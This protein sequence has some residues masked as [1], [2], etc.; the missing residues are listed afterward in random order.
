MHTLALF[1]Q[2]HMDIVF[3]IYG[4]AFFSLGLVIL[5]QP[6]EE[7]KYGL[8]SIFWLLAVFGLVHG[9]LEW[10]DLWGIVRGKTAALDTVKIPFLVV[11]YLFL[12]EFGR[13]LLLVSGK[14][15]PAPL[16]WL[17]QK[18]VYAWVAASFMVTFFMIPDRILATQISARYFLGLTGACYTG[19]GFFLY[20][21]W[22]CPQR[23]NAPSLLWIRKYFMLSA[24]AFLLYGIAAGLIVPVAG[25][26][27]ANI[28]NQEWFLSAFKFP[29]QLVRTACAVVAAIGVGNI[30]RIFHQEW[31]DSLDERVRQRT[32]ELESA[33]YQAD[34]SNRSKSAF[35]A[36][37]S[38][39]IRTPLNGVVGM[40]DLL[41]QTPLNLEQQQMM[42]TV[43]DSA[44]SLL[45]IID[46]ILD[47]SKIEA[48]RLNVEQIPL[49]IAGTVEG[50]GD[51]LAP[52]ATSKEL[53]LMVYAAPDLPSEVQG[54]L[55]RLRQILFNLVGNA[56]KFTHS[57]GKENPGKVI[58]RAD[59]S[60]VS[61]TG[62]SWVDFRVT[63][64]GIG[65]SK[66]ALSGL[67]QPFTQA[68]VS[69][70]RR[71]GGTGLGLV[72][73]KRLTELMGGR[74]TVESE[75]GQGSTFT[76]RI[77]FKWPDKKTQ[78]TDQHYD[79]SGLRLLCIT[80]LP[81]MGE[82]MGSYLTS[83]GAEAVL[84]THMDKLLALVDSHTVEGR[85]FDAVIMSIT[86]DI[87]Q[88]VSLLASLRQ[89]PALAGTRFIVLVRWNEIPA[90]IEVADTVLIKAFPIH[91][92]AL[93][94]AVAIAVG[95][96]IPGTLHTR[97]KLQE[98]V[99]PSIQDAETS[100]ELILV[101]EDNE[102]NQEVIR[103]QLNLL[104][105]AADLA[106]DGK[107][108]MQKWNM[109]S[110]GLVLTDCHMPEMDGFELTAAIRASEKC[111][112]QRVPI[113]AITA[114]V[115]QGEAER[116][117]ES[118]MDDYLAKPVDLAALKQLLEKWLP[119]H[120]QWIAA[121]LPGNKPAPPVQDDSP[122]DLAALVN[123]VGD[124]PGVH[125]TL[126]QKFIP[127][128]RKSI[129]E[130][131]SARKA[132]DAENVG[133]VAHRLKSSAR[134]IG[135]SKLADACETLEAAGKS[136]SWEEINAM[137][138][139]LHALMEQVENRINTL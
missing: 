102:V 45:Q 25:I 32:L 135:A 138:P 13:R 125:R 62:K 3:F 72:I 31:I 16:R 5:A 22:A 28:I 80:R 133:L 26:F 77:P 64:N 111:G 44:F 132:G 78:V 83:A 39:E 113:V 93:L 101:A 116:C 74:I 52:N 118:G 70:T 73:T 36:A 6:K 95:R 9:A 114:N 29:V 124:N 82:F 61:D 115:M 129:E 120:N 92:I 121:S 86:W 91:R 4:L 10:L 94:R 126:L 8:A 17:V 128:A 75:P 57:K 123:M 110:Y 56:I 69:T 49:S 107:T 134:T 18:K 79:L 60:P 99:I 21:K 41:Q 76:V 106:I 137:E 37:M 55:V 84:C 122:L 88:R 43:K 65:M 85:R 90:E 42:G 7:S 20:L 127:L 48:G 35:L 81:E 2:N 117:L 51:L 54:D 136:G 50:V 108:A 27:P 130:I 71:F 67:F 97:E 119:R 96:A 38:H 12:F 15:R 34:A 131:H 14:A 68:D 100:G 66:D 89:H 1:I 98:Q 109:R 23:M 19:L 105:Y 33:K 103:R 58:I 53:C 47:F 11:S 46:D 59:L 87:D 24:M 104:G 139:A 112:T 40:I 63:D 30:L